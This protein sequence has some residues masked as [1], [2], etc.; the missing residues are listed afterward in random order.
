MPI[1]KGNVSINS[2]VDGYEQ[3]Q[4]T[5]TLARI[6]THF[7]LFSLALLSLSPLSPFS[8]SSLPPPPSLSLTPILPLFRS[9]DRCI[10]VLHTTYFN[11]QY[12]QK[13]IATVTLKLICIHYCLPTSKQHSR[14]SIKLY[15]LPSRGL[16]M[17]HASYK[18]LNLIDN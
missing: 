16:L 4:Y 2:K 7:S 15:V 12:C 11:T 3:Q 5:R 6:Y 13:V 18:T 9:L 10:N 17:Y 14:L 8:R 1:Y